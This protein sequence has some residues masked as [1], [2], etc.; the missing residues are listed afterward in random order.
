MDGDVSSSS[1]EA[2]NILRNSP[3]NYLINETNVTIRSRRH[4]TSERF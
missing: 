1:A 3:N 4:Y 2:E